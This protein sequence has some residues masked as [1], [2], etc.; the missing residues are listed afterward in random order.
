MDKKTKYRKHCIQEVKIPIFSQAWWLDAVAGKDNWDVVIIEKGGL[1]VASMPY[2]FQ[3]RFGQ[4]KLRQPPLTQTLGPWIREVDGKQAS[5]LSREKD[6]LEQLIAALPRYDDFNQSWHFSQTNWLPF[7]WAGFTQTTRYTYRLPDIS[8]QDMLWRG[9]RENIKRE[10]RK[11]KK[12]YS[13]K[14]HTDKSIEVFLD[15]HIKTFKRQGKDKLNA[16]NLIM[17]LNDACENK[18]A[19]KIFIAQDAEGKSYAGVYLVWDQQSAY[20]LMGGS[21]PNLRTSGAISLCLWEAI[22][23]ASTVT[24]SFD[25]EGS[26]KETIERH[27]RAFGAKQTMYFSVNHT[28]SKLIRTVNFVRDILKYKN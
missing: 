21:E 25:F 19:R 22:K 18:N 17:R 2:V 26:M 1:V 27:F 4:I 12:R 13:L 16:K 7:Y 3:K 20:Y 15:L 9:L 14:V 24:K 8:N 28:P 6:L 11:A 10:I 5:R 23:F